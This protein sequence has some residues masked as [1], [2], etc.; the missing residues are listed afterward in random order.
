MIHYENLKPKT[1]NNGQ[2]EGSN[3]FYVYNDGF[4][5]FKSE[6]ASF[7]LLVLPKNAKKP[8]LNSGDFDLRF[9]VHSGMVKV[10]IHKVSFVAQSGCEFIVPFGKNQC[11]SYSLNLLRVGNQYEITNV[12]VRESK[13]YYVHVKHPSDKKIRRKVSKT[14]PNVNPEES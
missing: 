5:H 9:F 4:P 2:E 12:H 6:D 14:D 13:L 10:T 11:F 3:H 7:G 1:F 8:N